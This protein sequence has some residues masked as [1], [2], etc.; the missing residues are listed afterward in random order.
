MKVYLDTGSGPLL[1]QEDVELKAIPQVGDFYHL[2]QLMPGLS[3][4]LSVDGGAYIVAERHFSPAM[5]QP[6][7]ATP[8]LGVVQSAVESSCEPLLRILRALYRDPVKVQK[9]IQTVIPI[10]EVHKHLSRMD[11]PAEDVVYLKLIASTATG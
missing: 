7:A 2:A 10:G 9:K 3:S 4:E 11:E 6:T 8:V 1:C 5:P